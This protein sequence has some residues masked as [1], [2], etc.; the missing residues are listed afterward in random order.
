MSLPQYFM[1]KYRHLFINIIKDMLILLKLSSKQNR[2]I[3]T[4]SKLHSELFNDRNIALMSS[5]TEKNSVNKLLKNK[6]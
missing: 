1:P 3:I 4:T 5:R 6:I 2:K